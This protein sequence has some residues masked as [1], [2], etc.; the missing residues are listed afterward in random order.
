MKYLEHF[1]HNREMLMGDDLI[2]LIDACYARWDAAENHA[3]SEKTLFQ[4]LDECL[5]K[6]SSDQ[7]SLVERFYYDRQ[8]IV[9]IAEAVNLNEATIRKRMERIRSMLKDCIDKNMAK[10]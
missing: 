7:R 2:E 6:L 4:V 9:E 8:R 5:G 1:R 10:G 3:L